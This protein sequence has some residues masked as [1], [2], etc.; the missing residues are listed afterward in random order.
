MGASLGRGG[1]QPVEVGTRG[2]PHDPGSDS[3]PE[4]TETLADLR[5]AVIEACRWADVDAVKQH[6]AL[7]ECQPTRKFFTICLDSTCIHARRSRIRDAPGRASSMAD[8][9]R[10][11][12]WLLDWG[13]DPDGYLDEEGRRVHPLSAMCS[14][15]QVETAQIDIAR[16]LL[17]R[18]A[19][20]NFGE[21]TSG[22]TALIAT[23]RYYHARDERR[24]L[25]LA[26]LLLQRGADVHLKS[27]NNGTAIRNAC[28]NKRIGS[29]HPDMKLPLVRLLLEHGAGSDL[30]QKDDFG[31]TPLDY[32]HEQGN[33]RIKALLRKYLAITIHKYVVGPPAEHPFRRIEHQAPL[34]ASFLI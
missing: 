20:V 21:G 31:K 22:G 4:I 8:R 27:S 6:F 17:D 19:D 33:H 24:F 13:A 16:L 18:G 2:P 7:G 34:I 12:R 29:V 28:N 23:C 32:A 5:E 25:A 9:L 14:I 3:E 1:R 30:Y 10:L 15:A 26:R 11:A